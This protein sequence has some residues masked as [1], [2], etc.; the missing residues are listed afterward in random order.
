VLILGDLDP[1]PVETRGIVDPYGRDAGVL[2]ASF[3]R[4]E[5]CTGV[6]ARAAMGID[7]R[8]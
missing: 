6:L 1:E 2:A 3:A 7:A 5:R 8:P 4:I